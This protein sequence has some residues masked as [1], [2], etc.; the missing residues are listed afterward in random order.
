MGCTSQ[1]SWQME[2]EENCLDYFFFGEPS[3]DYKKLLGQYIRLTGA[4][5]MIPKWAFGF[6]MSKC[7]YQTREEIEEVV[8]KA[9]QNGIP[10]DVIL[11]TTGRKRR[12]WAPGNGM[13][14]GSRIPRE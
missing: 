7:S 3:G 9:E 2:A 14:N 6:W 12:R 1:V 13:R 4:I 5:P 8:T 11:M 10:L